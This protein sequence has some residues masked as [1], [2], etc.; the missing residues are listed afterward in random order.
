MMSLTLDFLLIEDPSSGI[1]KTGEWEAV[2]EK[3]LLPKIK[4]PIKI[5]DDNLRFVDF[6]FHEPEVQEKLKKDEI[7]NK[8]KVVETDKK[9]NNRKKLF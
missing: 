8:I 2:S 5:I 9:K 3:D 7:S 6:N 4:T 1:D